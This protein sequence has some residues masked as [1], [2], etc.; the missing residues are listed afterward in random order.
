MF[1]VELLNIFDSVAAIPI[2]HRFRFGGIEVD[3]Q[4]ASTQN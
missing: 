1:N 2:A 3:G 4:G